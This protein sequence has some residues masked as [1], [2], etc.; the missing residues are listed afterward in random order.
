MDLAER[1]RRFEETDLYVVIT[2][3]FC[4]GRRAIDVLEAILEAGVAMVQ[5]REKDLEGGELYRRAAAFRERTE[6]HGALLIIDDRVDVA[7]GV[8]ADGVH[9]GQTD[10]PIDVARRIAPDLI[11]GGSTHGV[12]EALA[13]QAAGASYLNIGPIFATQTKSTPMGAVGP[14]LISRVAPHLH[15]PFT[16]MGGIKAHNVH[17]VVKRGARHVA[18]VTAVTAAEDPCA[19]AAEL[20]AAIRGRARR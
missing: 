13:T 7:L 10:L 4:A 1:M 18:V 12:E 2:E 9:L 15:V 8:G 5:F 20:R 3:A 19:A 16:C 17:E 14:D 11:L 6:A